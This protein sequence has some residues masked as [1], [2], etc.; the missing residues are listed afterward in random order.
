MMVP[1]LVKTLLFRSTIQSEQKPY[2]ERSNGKFV[3]QYPIE[4]LNGK[5]K[6]EMV[7]HYGPKIGDVQNMNSRT[8]HSNLSGPLLGN[9]S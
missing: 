5:K 3:K 7:D 8:H 6:E 9:T 2:T 4:T 1:V